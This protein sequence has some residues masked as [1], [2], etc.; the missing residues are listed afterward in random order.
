VIPG[1]PLHVIQRGNNRTAIFRSPDDFK[2]FLAILREASR[3]YQCAI[4]AYVL[5]PNHVHLLTTPEDEH[6]PARMMQAVGRQF[7]YYVNGRYARTG[8]LWEGRYRSSLVHTER[9]AFTCSRYIELNPVRAGMTSDAGLY[10]W[11]SYR[12]NA[13]GIPDRLITP[14]LLYRDLGSGLA[15]RQAAYRALFENAIEP[16][17]LDAIRQAAKS[18]DI[19]GE[20]AF[21]QRVETTLQRSLTRPPH[22]GD[23]RSNAFKASK[24]SDA[25]LSHA[26]QAF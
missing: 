7:T 13:L 12:H 24:S 5:M 20:D 25:P 10:P 17:E 16:Q 6:G 11:S 2:C 23:R 19:L 4:H 21:R 9:Y 8:T 26:F 22:G 1:T 14:Q 15:D 3:R 18:G